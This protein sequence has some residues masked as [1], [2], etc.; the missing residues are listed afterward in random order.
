MTFTRINIISIDSNNNNKEQKETNNKEKIGVVS[1]K[2]TTH[3]QY[4]LCSNQHAIKDKTAGKYENRKKGYSLLSHKRRVI[5][6]ACF[7][8]MLSLELQL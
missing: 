1:Y 6:T 7:D 3:T 5:A 8:C 2:H 4:N